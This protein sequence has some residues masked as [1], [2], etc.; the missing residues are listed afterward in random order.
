ME[1]MRVPAGKFLMGDQWAET[2]K[3]P[4]HTVDIPYDYWMARFPVTN[5]LYNNSS[6]PQGISHPVDEWE[7]KKDHP[8]VSVSMEDAMAYCNG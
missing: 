2:M 4:K 6:K 1:F 3:Y 5:E 7:K 8:V